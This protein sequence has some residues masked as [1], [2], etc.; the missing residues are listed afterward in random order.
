MGETNAAAPTL[1][2]IKLH[3]SYYFR[4]VIF[5]VENTLFNVPRHHFESVSAIFRDMFDLPQGGEL[6][7]EG[8][9]TDRPIHLE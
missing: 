1:D 4:M 5:R 6:V 7:T 2:G 8:T 9:S 3:A